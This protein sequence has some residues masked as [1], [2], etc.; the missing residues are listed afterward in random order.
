MHSFSVTCNAY[1]MIGGLRLAAVSSPFAG[2]AIAQL[3]ADAE[4]VYG[5]ALLA[6]PNATVAK[7]LIP[8]R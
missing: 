3:A 7:R 8:S 4:D 1:Q 5:P 2:S 6:H